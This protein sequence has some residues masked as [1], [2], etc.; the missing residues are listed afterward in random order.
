[1]RTGELGL[2]VSRP[3]FFLLLLSFYI[4][5]TDSMPLLALYVVSASLY[6]AISAV[7]VRWIPAPRSWSIGALY[8]EILWTTGLCLVASVYDPGGPMP[9]LF[10]PIF[11]TLFFD[12]EPPWLRRVLALTIL[13]WLLSFLPVFQ[14]S[15]LFSGLFQAGLYGAFNLFSGAM[16]ALMRDLRDEKERSE[17][18]LTQVQESQAALE[19]AHRQLT[20]S[21]ARQQE[22]AVLQERQRLAREI[23]DS[24]AHSLTALVVQIQAARRLQNLDPERSAEGLV[25]CEEMS[26]QALLETRQAVRA[27]H[28]AG[29]SQATELEALRRLGRDFGMATGI[30]ISVDADEGASALPPDPQ[31][32]EQ[33]YRIFQ[34]ALTNAHRHGEARQVTAQLTIQEGSLELQ[35]AND[36]KPPAT[37]EPGLGLR[38]MAERARSL[39]GAIRFEP[40]PAG[41][42][43]RVTVPVKQE[44]V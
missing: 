12:L 9:A 31:R 17:A 23:H 18:L 5:T 27:L 10:S 11:V 14:R 28:P 36:G 24:V 20:E 43:I 35:I 3:A 42:T 34:E 38:A 8:L 40:G 22:M 19:R 1:M 39:G 33:L 41:L 13:L 44:P 25:R 26:R 30:S 16:G 2:A 4:I 15:D 37:L 32:L 29:L 6:V 7:I 21:A